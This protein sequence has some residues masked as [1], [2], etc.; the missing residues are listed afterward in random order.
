MFPDSVPSNQASTSG[1]WQTS[2][3]S[4]LSPARADDKLCPLFQ[5]LPSISVTLSICEFVAGVSATL[6][7]ENE[8]KVPLEAFFPMDGDSAVYSIKAMAHTNY[9]NAISQGH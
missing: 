3:S 8:G 1:L 6:N 2:G 7:Y 4:I 5:L 9:E